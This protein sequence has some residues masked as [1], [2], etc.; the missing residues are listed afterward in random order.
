[1]DPFERRSTATFSYVRMCRA[2][3]RQIVTSSL[4]ALPKSEVAFHL[5]TLPLWGSAQGLWKILR[6][7]LQLPRCADL[8]RRICHS[9]FARLSAATHPQ[10]VF[11]RQACDGGVKKGEMRGLTLG[12]PFL[13]SRASFGQS[14]HGEDASAVAARLSSFPPPDSARVE[15]REITLRPKR[16]QMSP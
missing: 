5:F 1:M 10:A 13:G 7:L 14:L 15:Q 12:N 3:E 6:A 2:A 16:W 4:A 11:T 9:W 8:L